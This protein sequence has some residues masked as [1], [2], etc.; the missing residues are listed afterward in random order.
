MSEESQIYR[1]LQKY[2]DKLPVGFP[3]TDSGVEI[4]VLK[5]LFTPLEAQ[6]ALKLDTIPEPVNKI[7]RHVKKIVNSK[8]NLKAHLEE[9]DKKGAI[10]GSGKGKR[11]YYRLQVLV[12]G[13]YEF[14]INR[15]TKEFMSDFNQYIE[16]GFAEEITRT[17]IYQVRT[18]PVEKALN[19]RNKVFLYDDI[20]RLIKKT[21]GKIGLADCICRKGQDLLGKPCKKTSLRE[22]CLMFRRIA[23][24]YISHNFAKPIS[25][26]IALEILDKAEN[27]GL[28]LQ[29]GNY[30]KLSFICT[31]CSCCCEGLKM[32]K[33]FDSPA[34]FYTSS[35][36][37]RID[38]SLCKKCKTCINRCNMEAISFNNEKIYI[39]KNKCIGCGICVVKCPSKAIE[40]TRKE[41]IKKPPY[42]A[43]ALFLKILYKKAGALPVIKI[44]LKA[45]L[46]TRLSYLIRRKST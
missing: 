11:K 15:L 14:Q 38:Y 28:I 4:R 13:M 12:A 34:K 46:K 27:E 22:S 37:A 30:Q 23:D 24:Y 6:I 7:Y 8:E 33:K 36:Y 9:M 41:K 43:F 19:Y 32:V 45:I 29:T 10:F 25:K 26:E 3:K 18:V 21:N 31:C 39:N 40:L 17:N 35:Y 2:L 16:E 20:R 44:V 1:E 42:G 5:H